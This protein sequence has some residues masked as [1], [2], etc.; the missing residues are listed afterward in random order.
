MNTNPAQSIT[1]PGGC[2]LAYRMTGASGGTPVVF[3][4]GILMNLASWKEQ[5]RVFSKKH[6]CLVHD[7]R[8]QLDSDK[9]FDGPASMEQHVNDLLFLLDELNIQT[10]HVIGTSYGG[11]VALL[12]AKK[13]PE[14]VQ[15]LSVIASVSYS[16]LLL[17]KQVQLWY[18]LAGTSPGLLHDSVATLA[19]SAEFMEQYPAILNDRK[20]RFAELPPSFFHGFR[21]LC[22]AF[23]SFEISNEELRQVRC[24]ALIVAA[25]EDILKPPRYSRVIAAHLPDATYHEVPGAGHA[26]VVE[27]PR[28]VNRLLRNFIGT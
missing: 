8:G 14:R 13:H 11:E 7:F 19:Y 20:K 4:N 18:D 6:P 5:V 21:Q 27:Q 2:Q 23:L 3:L 15:S 16:D 24:P 1:L 10:C 12:F 9:V 28:I 17:K 22:E 26:V 25:A